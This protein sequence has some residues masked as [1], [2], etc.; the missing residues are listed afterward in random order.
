MISPE[1]V[2]LPPGPRAEIVTTDGRTSLATVVTA[3]DA[4]LLTAAALPVTGAADDE[5][6][7]A[8]AAPISP[9]TT[10]ATAKASARGAHGHQRRRGLPGSRRSPGAGGRSRWSL[11]MG[12]CHS[13]REAAVSRPSVRVPFPP[14]SG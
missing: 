13:S 1:P 4:A 7:D 10:P 8:M 5:A 3:Q 6:G 2:P 14:P 9:P 11:T 12:S